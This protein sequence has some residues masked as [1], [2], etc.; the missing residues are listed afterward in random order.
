MSAAAILQSAE[1]ACC[2][3]SAQN[4]RMPPVDPEMLASLA[5]AVSGGIPGAAC[6]AEDVEEMRIGLCQVRYLYLCWDGYT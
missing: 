6:W 3:V 1:A 5:L 2:S 4:P